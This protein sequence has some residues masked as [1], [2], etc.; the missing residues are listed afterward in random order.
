VLELLVAS[1]I[2]S[3]TP[4]LYATLGEIITERSGVL[5]LGVEGMMTVGALAGFAAATVTGSALVGLMCALLGAGFL[6]L[7]HAFLSVTLRANQ[8]VS[9]LGLTIFGIGLTGYLGQSMI[10][11]P[12]PATFQKIFLPYVSELPFVGQAFFQHNSLVYLCVFL[13]FL[14]YLFL[15]HTK[16]GLN[17]RAVGD[18]PGA[19]DMAGVS[20]FLIRYVAV[21]VGGALCGL[22][23]AYV[24]LVYTPFWTENMIAGRGWIAIALVIFASWDPRLAILGAFLF[25]GV[26]A[27]ATHLQALGVGV[28]SYFLRMLPYAFTIL[29]LVLSSVRRGKQKGISAVPA[30]LTIPYERE[31]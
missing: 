30:A 2:A 9:G 1:S 20:V 8:V 5:N 31:G 27:L 3:A 14:A 25:G 13:T 22:G 12:A 18:D 29:I 23:G 7:I 26:D 24:S 19:A 15:F 28:S 16:A 10:G 4:L 17:L 21:V 11:K 6:S